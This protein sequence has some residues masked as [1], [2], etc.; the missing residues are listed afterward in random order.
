ME[1]PR[2]DPCIGKQIELVVLVISRRESFHKRIGIRNS[3]AKDANEKMI[4]RYVIGDPAEKEENGE[5]LNKILDEEQ[6]QFG[7]LI[8]YYNIMEGYHFLQFKTGA[9]FQ[10]QQ[11][12]C[13][14]AEYVMK[15]DDDVIIDLPRWAFW[16][17]HKFKKQLTE[18]KN[19]LAFFGYLVG[20]TPT[21]REKSSKWY[22]IIMIWTFNSQILIVRFVWYPSAD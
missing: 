19:G 11:K 16:N 17:E 6:E 20:E 5:K 22:V 13:R 2:I 4:I 10:W 12:W 14:N 3:W 21:I 15:I 18:T 8:R 9:A 1:K 7:D